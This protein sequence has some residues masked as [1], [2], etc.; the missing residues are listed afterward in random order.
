MISLQSASRVVTALFDSGGGIRRKAVRGTLWVVLSRWI[1]KPILFVQTIILVRLLEPTD[2]GLMGLLFVVTGT[3]EVFV[4]PGMQT[5]LIQRKEIN[6]AALNTAWVVS[7]SGAM[8]KAVLLFMAA[9]YVASFYETAILEQIVKVFAISYLIGGFKNIGMVVYRREINIKMITYSEELTKLLQVVITV[10]LAFALRNVWALVIGQISGGVISVFFS[11]LFSPY[12]P[13]LKFDLNIA[14]GLFGFGRHIFLSGI[15]LLM[16]NQGDRALL[17]K[18]VDLEA[19]GFYTMAY[20]LSM[21]PATYLTGIIGQVIFPAFSR[22]NNSLSSLKKGYLSII[23]FAALVTFPGA[24]GI[25]IL[26]PEIVG[27]VYG[28]K[29]LPMVDTL[30]VLSLYGLIRLIYG[31]NVALFQ[32]TGRP[33][34]VTWISAVRLILM[35][36]IIFPLTTRYGTLGVG[37]AVVIP[38]LLIQVWVFRWAL[39]IVQEGPACLFGVLR[40]PLFGMAVMTSVL[41]TVRILA[42]HGAS[43]TGLLGL[44]LLGVVVYS[45][46]ILI[47]DRGI[48]KEIKGLVSGFQR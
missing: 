20:G 41:L 11:Y 47:A 5:A 2:F 34:Y 18:I 21:L 31:V 13:S 12:R 23:K 15:I 33:Y 35:A 48:V 10:A 38:M 1:T 19:V 7:I 9:P 4:A 46:S 8:I 42:G 30:R 26:A 27:I 45:G 14:R 36:V 43:I 24:A 44:I 6:A 25:F 28:E 3:I 17:G 39:K 16:I 32:G 29:W 22:V 37:I 40:F